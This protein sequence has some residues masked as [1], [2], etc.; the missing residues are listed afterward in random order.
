MKLALRI[1]GIPVLSAEEWIETPRTPYLYVNVTIAT[2]YHDHPAA[3]SVALELHQ[4]VV[5]SREPFVA[6]S[7]ST[8]DTGIVNIVSTGG[9]SDDIRRSLSTLTEF[10]VED[11]SAAD[12]P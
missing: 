6:T 11:F 3:Y 4:N 5:L 12:P 10:F 8:W 9:L 1:A 2:V 7:S